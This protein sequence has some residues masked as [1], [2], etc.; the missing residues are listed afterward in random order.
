MEI[1]YTFHS[2][3]LVDLNLMC[4]TCG[5]VGYHIDCDLTY[6]G[7]MAMDGMEYHRFTVSNVEEWFCNCPPIEIA[8]TRPDQAKLTMPVVEKS[9]II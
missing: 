5:T 8:L 7:V 4:H 1:G 2:S 9:Q 6:L 3:E